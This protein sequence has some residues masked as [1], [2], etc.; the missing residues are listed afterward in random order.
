MIDQKERIHFINIPFFPVKRFV[1]GEMKE[2]FKFF[3]KESFNS[4]QE[5]IDYF[6]K[7][8]QSTIIGPKT[9]ISA[10]SKGER[11]KINKNISNYFL[12]M[13]REFFPEME[14]KNLISLMSAL[15]RTSN[16]VLI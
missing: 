13:G 14:E 15:H 4:I 7:L 10:P 1:I 5:A 12:V 16:S 3:S 11:D 6:F 2:E 8:K 9:K